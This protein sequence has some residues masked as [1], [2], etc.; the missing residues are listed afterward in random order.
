MATDNP[1]NTYLLL[2]GRFSSSSIASIL[3][4]STKFVE[5][6]LA[7]LFL[8]K[9]AN[10]DL[11]FI[12]KIE[13]NIYMQNQLLRDTDFMSMA[14]SVEVRVPFLDKDFLDISNGL[15]QSIRYQSKKLLKSS[16]KNIVP[17]EIIERKKMGF[18]FPFSRWILNKLDYFTEFGNLG[19]NR[20]EKR[21][22]ADFKAGKLNWSGFWSLI[23][24]NKYSPA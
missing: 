16:F 8:D 12:S 20:Y 24:L 17:S 3:D 5:E 14:N 7:L 1:L 10:T 18:T 11:D 22:I 23:V 19:K 2:R 21:L 4:T 15:D 13:T 9:E 6:S